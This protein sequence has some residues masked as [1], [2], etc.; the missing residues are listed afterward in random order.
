VLNRFDSSSIS[1]LSREVLLG[2][3]P[4][5]MSEVT[6]VQD[7]MTVIDRLGEVSILDEQGLRSS[8]IKTNNGRFTNRVAMKYIKPCR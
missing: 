1:P 3:D 5:S 8:D 4:E 2:D 6:A 7:A